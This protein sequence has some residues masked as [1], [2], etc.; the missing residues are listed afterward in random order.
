MLVRKRATK[1]GATSSMIWSTLSATLARRPGTRNARGGNVLGGADYL[2]IGFVDLSRGF[3]AR[4]QGLRRQ[5]AFLANEGVG[6]LAFGGR[7]ILISNDG[8]TPDA[9]PT[10][11]QL[12]ST[13]LA[14]TS[15]SIPTLKQVL[16]VIN[17]RA[18]VLIEIKAAAGPSIPG[19][20]EQRVAGLL[21]NYD[22]PVG[23]MSL[24]PNPLAWVGILSPR[25]PLGN[26]VSKAHRT[27]VLKQFLKSATRLARKL[28]ATAIAKSDFVAVDM[29]ILYGESIEKV[30]NTGKPVLTWTVT[31][32]DSA[33][34]AREHADALIFEGF[35]LTGRQVPGE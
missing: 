15:E 26:V 2:K 16:G 14:G 29:Q 18:P 19:V 34:S 12:A 1:S 9:Q 35:R 20:L 22:G 7:G 28:G 5:L 11:A 8:A 32:E 13:R 24:S 25:T 31:S 23:A 33:T 30:R 17:G 3:V 10:S 4:L 21:G 6:V 27:N